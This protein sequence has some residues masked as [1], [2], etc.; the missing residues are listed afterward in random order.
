MSIYLNDENRLIPGDFFNGGIIGTGSYRFPEKSSSRPA[1]FDERGRDF[2]TK[3]GYD[4]TD[5]GA[6]VTTGI[7]YNLSY[8]HK[9][10]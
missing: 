9:K 2:R 3:K 4:Q 1:I 8:V 10:C 7:E 5:P 6:P